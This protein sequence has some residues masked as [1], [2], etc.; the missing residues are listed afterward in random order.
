MFHPV[1]K[2]HGDRGGKNAGERVPVSF[3]L[4]YIHPVVVISLFIH[5]CQDVLSNVFIHI[6]IYICACALLYLYSS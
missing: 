6:Y 3:N 2:M 5:S 1:L 4:I